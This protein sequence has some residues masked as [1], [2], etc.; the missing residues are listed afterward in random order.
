MLLSL[1]LGALVAAALL[2]PTAPRFFAAVFFIGVTFA[3][4]LL[5]SGLEGFAYY[6]SAA[7]FDLAIIFALGRLDSVP[8]LAVTL[9]R[10]CLVSIAANLIGWV[11]WRTYWPPAPYDYA[12][13]ALNAWALT[14]F[15]TG[16]KNDVV[17]GFGMDRWNSCLYGAASPRVGF[18]PKHG[19]K[20]WA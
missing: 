1:L 18:I 19:G 2:Q 4:E 16:T 9:Q 5:L 10:V 13:V 7:A 6:W 20:T 14:A 17:G 3:H 8:D 12:L 11:L 15:I